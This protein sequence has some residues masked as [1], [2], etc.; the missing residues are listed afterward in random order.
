MDTSLGVVFISRR[1][2]LSVLSKNERGYDLLI[3]ENKTKKFK[4]GE[5][6]CRCN[7]NNLKC[8]DKVFTLGRELTSSMSHLQHIHET[9]LRKFNCKIISNAC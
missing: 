9:A 7:E 4:S 2:L 3:L 1:H 5:A 8:P 6:F